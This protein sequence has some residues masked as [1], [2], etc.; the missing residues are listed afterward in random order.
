MFA[1]HGN[2]LSGPAGQVA[3]PLYP[4]SYRHYG[5]FSWRIMVD[6]G[7]AIAITFKEFFFEVYFSNWYSFVAVSN[8][9][10]LFIS[11]YKPVF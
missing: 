9:I 5:S 3:S 6:T 2:D 8:E 1:V 7:Q 11:V 4:R 10:F